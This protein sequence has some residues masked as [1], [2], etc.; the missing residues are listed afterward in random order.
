MS[1]DWANERYVRVYTRDTP[2]MMLWPWESRAIWPL[3]V[4]KA[5]RSGLIPTKHGLRALS[6]L[7]AIPIEVVTAGVAGLLEDGCLREVSGGGYL[8]P[9]YIEAQETPASDACPAKPDVAV[10]P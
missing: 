9:N 2:D 5:D 4:R 1:L 8:I 6:V 7:I 3:L 10:C